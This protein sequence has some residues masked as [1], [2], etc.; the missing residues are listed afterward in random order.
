LN[1]SADDKWAQEIL[2]GTSKE[3][4]IPDIEDLLSV[5]PKQNSTSTST[6][7][8]FEIDEKNEKSDENEKKRSDEEEKEFIEISMQKDIAASQNKKWGNKDVNQGNFDGNKMVDNSLETDLIE[9]KSLNDQ[10][11]ALKA[12]SS[13]GIFSGILICYFMICYVMLWYVILCYDMSCYV[14]L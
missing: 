6:L 12:P 14:M 11:N 2:L 13:P 8:K 3:E 4:I 10:L 1:I 9:A 5:N 7:T